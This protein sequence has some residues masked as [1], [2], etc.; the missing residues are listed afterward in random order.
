MQKKILS[1]YL[2]DFTAEE[3]NQCV[4]NAYTTEKFDTDK[5]V[6][7]VEVEKNNYLL[8]LWHGP[9]SAFKDMALS[10]LPHLMTLS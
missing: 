6:P 5:I 3:I 1:L 7:T 2:T 9:T 4:D 8:E 10:L